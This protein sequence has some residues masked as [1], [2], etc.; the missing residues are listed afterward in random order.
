MGKV[1]RSADRH[2]ATKGRVVFEFLGLPELVTPRG[3]QRWQLTKVVGPIYVITRRIVI[4]NQDILVFPFHPVPAL[5]VVSTPFHQH[6]SASPSMGTFLRS[7]LPNFS[8]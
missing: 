7:T 2:R 1:F 4:S 3:H 5:K 8:A 6:Y